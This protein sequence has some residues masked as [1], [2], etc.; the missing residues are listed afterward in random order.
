LPKR[1]SGKNKKM[2]YLGTLIPKLVNFRRKVC[3]KMVRKLASG[4][5]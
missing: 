3:S 2:A 1:F 5:L 4:K